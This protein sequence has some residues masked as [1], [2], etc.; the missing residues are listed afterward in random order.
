MTS[1]SFDPAPVAPAPPASVWEDFIDI[2][3]APRQVFLRR[4][5]GRFGLALLVNT[6]LIAVLYYMSSIVLA[7]VFE[8]EMRRG[9]EAALRDNPQVTAEQMAGMQKFGQI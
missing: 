7:S 2:F 9:M 8:A 1:P 4:I 6:V 3:Y 5:D